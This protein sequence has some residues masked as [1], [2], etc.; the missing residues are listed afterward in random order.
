VGKHIA[1]ELLKTGK[2]VVAAIT[3]P[4]S[5]SQLPERIDVVT[6]DYDDDE[7]L[8][9]AL[10]GQQFLV[11]TMSVLAPPDTHHMLVVAA[12]KAGVP[13]VMP[14]CYGTDLKNT[15]LAKGC[16]TGERILHA[17]AHIEKQ[18]VSACIVMVCNFWYEYS[19][20][21][22]HVRLRFSE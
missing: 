10:D 5:E 1:E 8:V 16:L 19:L 9:S 4:G 6:V 7:S 2:H 18:G 20:P 11:I 3:R 22:R 12:A 15:S 14:N 13:Y 21:Q 17:I